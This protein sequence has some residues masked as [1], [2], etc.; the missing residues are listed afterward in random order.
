[1]PKERVRIV[2]QDYLIGEEIKIPMDVY[3]ITIAANMTQT[4][5]P[6]EVNFALKQCVIVFCLHICVQLFW[7]FD[8]LDG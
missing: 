3:N 6:Y 7:A 2:E 5:S 8:Y 1:M 4:C